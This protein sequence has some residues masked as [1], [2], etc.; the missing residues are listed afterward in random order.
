MNHTTVEAIYAIRHRETGEYIKFGSKCAWATSG[1]AKNAWHLHGRIYDGF[2]EQHVRLKFD[3]QGKY[4]VVD[5]LGSYQYMKDGA[6]AA[7][8]LI[9]GL[10]EKNIELERQV[11]KLQG[12]L[13]DCF[14]THPTL[15]E[16]L[17][18]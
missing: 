16:S 2:A 12:D 9:D 6:N 14:L 8:E 10:L 13:E 4:E 17:G 5:I 11:L 7:H 15:R 3:D 18:Y 1:A